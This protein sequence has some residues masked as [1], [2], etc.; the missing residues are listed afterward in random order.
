[1]GGFK[2]CWDG[3]QGRGKTSPNQ[4]SAFDSIKVNLH[5]IPSAETISGLKNATFFPLKRILVNSFLSACWQ[6]SYARMRSL[7][8][9]DGSLSLFSPMLIFFP[10]GAVLCDLG[11]VCRVLWARYLGYVGQGRLDT[12][13]K[14]SR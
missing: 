12:L 9:E 3:R 10:M 2:Y 11:K 6:G 4:L 1:M 7:L 5:I 14:V 13:G 8:Y